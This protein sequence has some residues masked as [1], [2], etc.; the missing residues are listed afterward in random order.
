MNHSLNN[1]DDCVFDYL[2][3]HA[4]QPV[5]LVKIFNDIRSGSGQRCNELT[6]SANHRQ[7]FLAVC[8]S[9]D[10]SYKN[11]KKIHRNNKLY[12]VFQK[13]RNDNDIFDNS[14]FNDQQYDNTWKEEYHVKDIID[15]L[16]DNSMLAD[17]DTNYYTNMFDQSETLLHLLVRYNRYNELEK[18]LQSGKVDLNKKNNKG[19]T[20]LELAVNLKNLKMIKLLIERWDDG[21]YVKQLQRKTNK[22]N[23]ENK[24]V[25]VFSRPV[26]SRE[27]SFVES[28][29]QPST[30]VYAL[31]VW[32]IFSTALSFYRY[33]IA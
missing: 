3:L 10:R 23:K 14:S 32:Y 21:A 12:L 30:L 18:V 11:I 6:D 15:Y 29:Q 5:S 7:R 1:L 28:L 25:E 26:R 17:F 27:V 20:P 4:D 13:D 19:E 24:D 31:G 33:V 8:Y 22:P 9:L 16:C 2:A